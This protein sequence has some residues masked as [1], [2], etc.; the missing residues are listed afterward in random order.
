MFLGTSQHTL[1]EKLRL[2]LPKRD[3]E[4]FGTKVIIT[5][6]YDHNLCLYTAASFETMRAELERISVYDARG[7]K[8]K[9]IIFGNSSELN[10]D[11][12]GRVILPRN[13]LE[14]VGIRRDVTLVGVD[15]HIEV[16]DTQYRQES[17]KGDEEDLACLA[18]SILE[19]TRQ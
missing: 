19:P 12:H 10:V 14:L 18:Q 7:R 5:L 3:R 13:L 11:A 17:V 9:R 8:L 4:I 2:V 6:G 15:D 1:D 16:W